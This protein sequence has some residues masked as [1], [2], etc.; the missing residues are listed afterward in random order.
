MVIIP[1]IDTYLQ[2]RVLRDT[3]MG[4]FEWSATESNYD[5]FLQADFSVLIGGPAQW[6]D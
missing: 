1:V 4:Y 5:H 6:G 2:V 3:K